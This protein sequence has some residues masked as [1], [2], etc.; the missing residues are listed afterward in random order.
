MS[1]E[2]ACFDGAYR[3]ARVFP[4]NAVTLICA[5]LAR[6]YLVCSNL[7]FDSLSFLRGESLLAARQVQA[8]DR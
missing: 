8:V 2:Y 7:R 3:L 5:W 1:L 6:I 4:L